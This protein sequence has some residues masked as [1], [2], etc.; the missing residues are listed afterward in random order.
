MKNKLKIIYLDFDDIRN[1]LLGAGQARATYNV[2]RELIRMGHKVEVITSKYPGWK[3]RREKGIYYRHVGIGTK[4][5]KLN[6]IVYALLAPWHLIGKKADIIIESFTAPFSV[7]F[8]PLFTSVPV[9]ALPS[10]FNASEFTKKYKLPFHLIEKFGLP[11][12]KYMLPYSNV[13]SA[14]AK[15]LNPNI[16]YKIVGQGVGSEFFQVKRKDLRYFLYYGR[17]DIA[18]KGVDILLKSYARYRNEL[19]YPLVIAGHGPDLSKLKEMVKDLNLEDNVRFIGP[20]YGKKKDEVFS[21]AVANVFP[22]RHDEICLGTLEVMASGIPVIAFN[23]P[24]SAWMKNSAYIVQ[25]F[26]ISKFGQA[27]IK[28]TENSLNSELSFRSRKLARNYKWKSV[29]KEFL[30]FFYYIR[31]IHAD[32]NSEARIH[33]FVTRK[34]V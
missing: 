10:M 9:V 31:K 26:S 1:P 6:N 25:R 16:I 32:S 17:L 22:S 23:L 19:Q 13:D 30:A 4:N 24:E 33:G 8:S 21:H 5:I 27:M 18:Q 14:K 7:M 12:Y 29:A 11:F 20:I 15:L 28:V 2:A 3:D 34:T